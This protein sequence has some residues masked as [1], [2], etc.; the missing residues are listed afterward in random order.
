M[1]DLTPMSSNTQGK[2]NINTAMK[3]HLIALPALGS[4]KVKEIMKAR[5]IRNLDEL[6]KVPKIT[7]KDI[8]AIRDL[9]T[10]GQEGENKM[11]CNCH[12][13]TKV[14][15]SDCSCGQCKPL[16]QLCR[17]RFFPGQLLTEEDLN[18]LECYIIAQIEGLASQIA[19]LQKTVKKQDQMLTK[20]SKQK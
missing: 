15:N 6:S 1:Q 10:F 11:S 7:A 13:S 8:E 19:D 18:R 20:L 4:A 5:P 12:S 16:K 9:I 2:Q 14:P 3:T 17:P